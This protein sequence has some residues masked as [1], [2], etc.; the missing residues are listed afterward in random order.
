MISPT[1]LTTDRLQLRELTPEIFNQLFVTRTKAQIMDYLGLKS[2]EEFADM[3]ERYVKG[4]TTYYTTFKGFHLIDPETQQVIGNCDFHTWVRSH[5]RA[6]IGYNLFDDTYKNKGLMKEALARILTFG[7]EEMELYRV[8]ALI[9]TYNIPSL[10]L[11]QHFGF[12][13]E[14]LL[15]NHYNV[16]GVLED[17]VAFSLLKPEFEDWQAKQPA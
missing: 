13:R 3:E 12:K 9:A 16:K 17:S 14:G 15:R 10:Q 6:E 4:L 8:E 7:F 1:V 2:D 5:R 11:V